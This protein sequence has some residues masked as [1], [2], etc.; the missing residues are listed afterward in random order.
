MVLTRL[1]NT[2]R[3][4]TKVAEAKRARGRRLEH[5][6]SLNNNDVIEMG[7]PQLIFVKVG[8]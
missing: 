2:V 5:S 7:K 4:Y 8:G 3:L 1:P 6:L